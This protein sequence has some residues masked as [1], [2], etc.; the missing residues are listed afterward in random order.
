[1]KEKPDW[2][3]V[4]ITIPPC[5]GGFTL[6]EINEALMAICQHLW[7]AGKIPVVGWGCEFDGTEL[8]PPYLH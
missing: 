6:E 2:P 1:M 4:R 3:R 7:D 5:P 8:F